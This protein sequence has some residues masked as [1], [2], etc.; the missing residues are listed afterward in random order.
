MSNEKFINLA[1]FMETWVRWR[2]LPLALLFGLAQWM[3]AAVLM[4][5]VRLLMG[6]ADSSGQSGQHPFTESSRVLAGVVSSSLIM[7]FVLHLQ[8]SD[9][10]IPDGL[11][12]K[13]AFRPAIFYSVLAFGAIPITHRNSGSLQYALIAG[14]VQAAT[15]L[16]SS[17][18]LRIIRKFI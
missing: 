1:G 4:H 14:V 12:L 3:A 5:E 9:R 10:G 8:V 13:Q 6:I 2:D 16:A 18:I 17:L 11:S 7:L 15:I